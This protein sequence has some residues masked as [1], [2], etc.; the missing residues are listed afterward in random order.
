MQNVAFKSV[1]T[2]KDHQAG[3]QGVVGNLLS[4]IRTFKKKELIESQVRLSKFSDE[5]SLCVLRSRSTNKFDLDLILKCWV[6]VVGPTLRFWD[7]K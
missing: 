5:H 6:N 4:L 3:V 1:L 7:P 2:N